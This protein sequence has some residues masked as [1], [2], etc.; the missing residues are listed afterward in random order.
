M[1]DVSLPLILDRF[2]RRLHVALQQRVPEFDKERVGAGGAMIILSLAD[3]GPVPMQELA[4]RLARDK[5][6]MT[7]AVQVLEKKGVV[8]RATSVHDGRVTEVALTPR[9]QKV[10]SGHQRVLGEILETVLNPLTAEEQEQFRDFL[11][12]L[13]S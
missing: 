12:R 9:G 2:V 4:R 6:Q 10:V 1:S 13:N 3:T 11:V 5:S 8:T 7:R